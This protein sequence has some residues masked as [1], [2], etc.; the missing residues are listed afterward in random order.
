LPISIVTESLDV[1]NALY[2]ALP[3]EF[4]PKF[5]ENQV[6]KLKTLY[7]HLDK[8]DIA[9]AIQNLLINNAEDA[10]LG[11]LG[12]GAG[13]LNEFDAPSGFGRTIGPAI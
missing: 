9:Q 11:R 4:K 12:K 3:D 1:T 5:R 6:G 7:R 13:Q 10:I 8:V 2:D